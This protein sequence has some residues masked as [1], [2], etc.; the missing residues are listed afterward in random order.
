MGVRCQG[1]Q[2]PGELCW[3]GDSLAALGILPSKAGLAVGARTRSA[4]IAAG[5]DSRFERC[6]GPLRPGSPTC[7]GPRRDGDIGGL[8]IWPRHRRRSMPP[9][10]VLRSGPDRRSSPKRA[11]PMASC[12]PCRSGSCRSQS[13]DTGGALALG[14]GRRLG[15]RDCDR[16]HGR[17]GF[18]V[19]GNES[20]PVERCRSLGVPFAGSR[21]HPATLREMSITRLHTI[22]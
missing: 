20:A 16:N 4:C 9:R 15:A 19:L 7:D 6:K 13:S 14:R 5:G 2:R 3:P 18:V 8:S 17:G 1:F 12:R 11:A 21:R 10:R 22:R